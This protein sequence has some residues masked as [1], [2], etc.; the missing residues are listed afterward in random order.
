MAFLSYSIF[1]FENRNLT[2]IFPVVLC[3]HWWNLTGWSYGPSPSKQKLYT[4][5]KKVSCFVVNFEAEKKEMLQR[6][7]NNEASLQKKVFSSSSWCKYSHNPSIFH[8]DYFSCI[9]LPCELN[10]HFKVTRRGKNPVV[11]ETL[12]LAGAKK[13]NPKI[14]SHMLLTGWRWPES[15]A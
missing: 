11:S 14:K 4:L 8:W 13:T 3:C 2:G 1:R 15:H 6:S 7:I 5:F 10:F 12:L 9:Y